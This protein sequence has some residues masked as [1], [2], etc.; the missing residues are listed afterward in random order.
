M[1]KNPARPPTH[2]A[3]FR[4]VGPADLLDKLHHDMNRVAQARQRKEAAYAAF[5]AAVSAWSVVD[6]SWEVKCGKGTQQTKSEH[7]VEIRTAVPELEICYAVATGAKHFTVQ[8]PGG[9]IHTTIV[10]VGSERLDSASGQVLK[11]ESAVPVVSWNDD[12]K[13]FDDVLA[14]VYVGLSAYLRERGLDQRSWYLAP[15]QDGKPAGGMGDY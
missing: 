8:S 2:D 10:L 13:L 4:M 11:D 7:V 1:A 12:S 5:D 15:E 14:N 3:R 9:D 6:W